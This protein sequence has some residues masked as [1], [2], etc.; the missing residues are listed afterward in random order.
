MRISHGD[1]DVVVPVPKQV[2]LAVEVESGE[3]SELEITISW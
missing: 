1:R 3:E 2:T